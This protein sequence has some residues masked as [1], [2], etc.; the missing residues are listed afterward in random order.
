[1]SYTSRW[2]IFEEADRLVGDIGLPLVQVPY[3]GM[4]FLISRYAGV[5]RTV[6]LAMDHPEEVEQTVDAINAAHENV[7]RLMADGPSQVLFH[8]DNLSSD[9]QSPHWLERYSGELLSPHGRNCS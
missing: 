7:M 6:M 8:S 3:T 4:G 1:M 2:D 5:E 9:V